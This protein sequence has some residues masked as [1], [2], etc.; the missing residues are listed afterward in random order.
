MNEVRASV[1]LLTEDSGKD[2]VLTVAEL[3]RR[4][5]V[6]AIPAAQT[7]RYRAEPPVDRALKNALRANLWKSDKPQDRVG[8]EELRRTIATRLLEPNGFVV[9]HFDI[10]RRWSAHATS[11]NLQRFATSIRAEV[12]RLIERTLANRQGDARR[13]GDLM[14]KLIVFA[15]AY[16]LE[17][18]LY[19]NTR[20]AIALCEKHHRGLDSDRF[21]AWE[22][23]RSLLDE[24]ERPKDATCLADKYN[25]ILAT[26]D[27]PTAAVRGHSPSFDAAIAS[28][29]GCDA[30]RTA[31]VPTYE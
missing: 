21:A 11:E 3:F 7:N 6:S 4:I 15:P 16:S 12:E 30:L 22:L 19:Q 9:F 18:W 25:S 17:A 27:F 28:V 14:R 8:V 23:D 29:G 2:A 10:D 5:V 24:V 26:E 31:L 20:R 13:S 1:L